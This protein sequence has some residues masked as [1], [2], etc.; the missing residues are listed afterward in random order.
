MNF[1]LKWS[2]LPEKLHIHRE[3]YLQT[4]FWSQ[5]MFLHLIETNELRFENMHFDL[6]SLSLNDTPSNES[7][8]IIYVKRTESLNLSKVYDISCWFSASLNMSLTLH[9]GQIE[10]MKIFE[11]FLSKNIFA[12]FFF[13]AVTYPHPRKVSVVILEHGHWRYLS[14]NYWTLQNSQ[15]YILYILGE[16]GCLS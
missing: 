10:L 4:H 12:R 6:S 16:R 5:Q 14:A 8:K 13:T 1:R 3:M 7:T 11:G 9:Q 15:W 2:V